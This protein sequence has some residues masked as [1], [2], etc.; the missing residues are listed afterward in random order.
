MSWLGLTPPKKF[1]TPVR[2]FSESSSDQFATA[3]NMVNNSS[4]IGSLLRRWYDKT[5][6][7]APYSVAHEEISD[8]LPGLVIAYGVN[9]AQNAMMKCMC[10]A[11]S[12]HSANRKIINSS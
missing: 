6:F 7:L 5:T 4:P 10:F 9:S 11:I 1:P 3:T 2:K 12:P 8:I